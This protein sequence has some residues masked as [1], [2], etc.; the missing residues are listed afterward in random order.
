VGAPPD[1]FV[2]STIAMVEPVLRRHGTDAQRE[3]F[4]EPLL[5]G[6]ETWCQLFSEPGAGSDLAALG[7]RA[8]RD[9]DEFV[10]DGQKVWTSNAHLCDWAILLART[11]PEAPKRE[12][13]TFFLLDLTTPGIDVRPLRQ[14]TGTAHFNEVFLTDVRI[15]A[16]RVVGGVG[17]GWAVAKTVLQH[18][19]VVIGSAGAALGTPALV[20]LADARGRTEEPVIRQ[21]LAVAHTDE[22]LVDH[23]RDGSDGSV[24]KLAWSE[25]KARR[26]ELGVDLLGPA[27]TLYAADAPEQ[28]RWQVE[29]LN[30]FWG[31][32]GGG[33]SEIHRTMVGER[34][35]GLPREPERLGDEV[36]KSGKTD[37]R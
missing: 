7:T 16:D 29:L 13:I 24:R 9:G 3:R 35:L 33:T 8:I 37:P 1:G 31:T 14:I 32:I 28:G 20:R 22:W 19:S 23:A 6:E 18:E 2:A 15:P 17:G 21:R 5:R 27:G 26:G 34:V 12:G 30:R 25:A 11:D 4:L 10:V 36:A